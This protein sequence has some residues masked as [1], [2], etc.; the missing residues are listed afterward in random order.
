MRFRAITF[1][2]LVSF[3]ILCQALIAQA[4]RVASESRELIFEFGKYPC[5]GFRGNID[6]LIGELQRNPRWGGIVINSGVEEDAVSALMREE[7][8]RNHVEFRGFDS[9]KIRYERTIATDFNTRFFNVPLSA[10]TS[11]TQRDYRLQGVSAPVTIRDYDFDDLCPPFDYLKFF[12]SVLEQNP[13]SSATILV[14]DRTFQLA[15][16]RRRK[17]IKSLVTLRKIEKNRIKTFLIEKPDFNYGND[18]YVEY[19]F[20]P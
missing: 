19:R 1:S 14:R 2:L 10:L 20:I 6:I 8:I 4:P 7:M 11:A 15:D 16:K 13:A 17:I 3:A 12:G 5:D 9:S 18:A